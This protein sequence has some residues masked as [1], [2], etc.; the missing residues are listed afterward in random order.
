MKGMARFLAGCTLATLLAS[1][2]ILSPAPAMAAG[3]CGD[4]PADTGDSQLS[5]GILSAAVEG[6]DLVCQPALIHDREGNWTFY[7][8]GSDVLRFTRGDL[9]LGSR[10]YTAR[11]LEFPTPR[12][13]LL[14]FTYEPVPP[15]S[16]AHLELFMEGAGSAAVNIPLAVVPGIAV[17]PESRQRA[18]VRAQIRAGDVEYILHGIRGGDQVKER[19]LDEFPCTPELEAAL[20]GIA[21]ERI[22]KVMPRYAEDDSTQWDARYLRELHYRGTQLRQYILYFEEGRSEAAYKEI[23]LGIPGVEKAFVNEDKSKTR[24]KKKGK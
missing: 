12:A 14:D 5:G 3:G 11:N 20:R 22:R 23:V 1:G 2:G 19:H 17:E 6:W 24:G 10:R 15:E 16:S 21:V 13:L 7:L 18:L 9:V 8:S 4:Q